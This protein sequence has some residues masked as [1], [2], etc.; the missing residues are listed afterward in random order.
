MQK[1]L[2][3]QEKLVSLVAVTKSIAT[4]MRNPLNYIYNFASLSQGLID[5]LKQQ[6]NPKNQELLNLIDVNLKKINE[7]SK[8]ADQIITSMLEQSRDSEKQKEP[9]NINK[10]I[11]DYAD[12][13]YYSY[14]KNDPLFSLTIQTD[15]DANMEPINVFPQNLGRVFYNIIDNA[16]YAT[17]LK[18][19]EL[20]TSYSPIVSI[21]TKNEDSFIM[22][23]VRDNGIGIPPTVLSRVFSPFLTTKPSGKGAGMGLSISH[24]IVVDDHGGTIDIRSEVGQFTELIITLP[25]YPFEAKV[26]P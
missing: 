12:L 15:Y 25:K 2:I 20:G 4:E 9:T 17:D 19:K 24:D 18:K 14:Y 1:K 6:S 13:V 10:L 11:R 16:C 3:Q 7:H 23:K 26:V 5:E 8:T 21:T 22:I